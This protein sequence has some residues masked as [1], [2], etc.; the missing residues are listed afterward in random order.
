MHNVNSVLCL[1]VCRIRNAKVWLK[2]AHASWKA[3]PQQCA[4]SSSTPA[5]EA[6]DDGVEELQP[7]TTLSETPVT[8]EEKEV[9]EALKSLKG[10]TFTK[11]KTMVCVIVSH[12]FFDVCRFPL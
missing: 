10:D 4:P 6:V 1:L 7:R 12:H 3:L 5:L 8:A 9:S 11:S 2:H